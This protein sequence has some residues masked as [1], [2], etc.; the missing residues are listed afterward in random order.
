M[1]PTDADLSPD[2]FD[3][4]R[5]GE[6][7]REVATILAADIS[8]K[9]ERR[10]TVDLHALRHTFGTWCA[11]CIAQAALAA[12]GDFALLRPPWPFLAGPHRAC[13][14]WIASVAAALTLS[15]S[16]GSIP[17]QSFPPFILAAE[18]ET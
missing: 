6:R 7:R 16:P 1:H 13:S 17:H 18:P 14:L 9:D 5:A 11:P 3:K 15:V 2:P 12:A 10:R 4:L 8:K